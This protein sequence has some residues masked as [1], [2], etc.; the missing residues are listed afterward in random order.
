MPSDVVLCS[1]DHLRAL[2]DLFAA[3]GLQVHLIADGA[4]IPGSFWGDSEAGLIGRQLFVRRDTPVHSALHEACHF[5]CM[6]AARRARL[7]TD[8]GGDLPEENAACYLQGLLADLIPGYTRLR[9]FADMDQW[10]YSF[11]LGSAQ[12]W[13]ERDARDAR[14]WLERHYII[15]SAQ[16]PTGSLRR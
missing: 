2:T 15:D 1:P 14:Q 12:A 13:F 9:L 11:R 16:R 6:D 8:A 4:P 10:G 5:I 3:Y 7:H